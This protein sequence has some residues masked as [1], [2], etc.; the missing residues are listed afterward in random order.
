MCLCPFCSL[1]PQWICWGLFHGFLGVWVH[2]PCLIL[3]LRACVCEP[4]L[5]RVGVCVYVCGFARAHR[6]L[7][8]VQGGRGKTGFL[9]PDL[10]RLW[11]LKHVSLF[12][13]DERRRAADPLNTCNDDFFIRLN[14]WNLDMARSNDSNGWDAYLLMNLKHLMR[15][16][17]ALYLLKEYGTNIPGL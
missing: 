11:L 6:G 17:I 15:G 12:R 8:S 5:V 1:A 16:V 2:L 3:N 14:Y 13:W 4:T 7:T 10:C 9:S